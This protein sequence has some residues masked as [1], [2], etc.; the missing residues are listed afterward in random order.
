MT[1]EE[2]MKAVD[3][4][5][6]EYISEA[7]VPPVKHGIFGFNG[8]KAVFAA[9]ACL[10]VF[11][12]TGIVLKN[13]V[14]PTQTTPTTED[15]PPVSETE[16]AATE[17]DEPLTT[18]KNTHP[19]EGSTA[20]VTV[21]PTQRPTEPPTEGSSAP[22]SEPTDQTPSSEFQDATEYNNDPTA[23]SEQRT[24]ETTAKEPT[25][26]PTTEATTQLPAYKTIT[27]IIEEM[28]LPDG[29][30]AG[31]GELLG[32]PDFPPEGTFPPVI[33]ELTAE[34]LAEVP[35]FV[36]PGRIDPPQG[37][38]LAEFFAAT[39]RQDGKTAITAQYVFSSENDMVTVMAIRRD[40]MTLPETAKELTAED[41]NGTEVYYT[42]NSLYKLPDEPNEYLAVFISKGILYV[43]P[44][45]GTE[46]DA[47]HVFEL[48][49][50]FIE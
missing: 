48:C 11:L 49:K 23:P 40:D 6:D 31:G 29:T 30:A 45:I 42:D 38:A 24:E 4:T 9:A 27:E 37:F 18:S 22:L 14:S 5:A 15:I 25:I 46:L 12:F 50:I 28:G 43:V 34:E 47:A 33:T 10:A 26:D 13:N 19:T 7:A 3:F 2:L 41:V 8:A 16:D 35:G 36:I 39:F 1:P 21:S 44:G 32:E 20:E 17:K